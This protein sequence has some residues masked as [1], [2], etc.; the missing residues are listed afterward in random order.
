MCWR[1]Y[2]VHVFVL[3]LLFFVSWDVFRWNMAFSYVYIFFQ[4]KRLL[5]DEFIAIYVVYIFDYIYSF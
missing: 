5:Q 4:F 2:G 1:L 3:G